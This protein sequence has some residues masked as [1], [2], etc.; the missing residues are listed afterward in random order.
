MKRPG[1]VIFDCDGVLVDSE[2]AAVQL[3]A[4]SFSRHGLPM[5]PAEIDLH[6][7]GGTMA[8]AGQKARDMGARLPAT[9]VE[10][11][12]EELYARLAAGTPL[13]DGIERVLDRLD[14]AGI[15]Y[16]VGSNGSQRKMGI[17]L[18]QH[19]ALMAR[20]AGRLYS[21]QD[22]LMTKPD[23]G[24][25]LRIAADAGVD[26]AACAVVDDSASGVRAGVAAGMRTL[27]F[28][29]HDEGLRLRSLGAEVFHRMADLPA[30]LGL[31]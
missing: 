6:F 25:F 12:Y 21:G 13:I 2:P 26:P 28:A 11:T 24:M 27:G 1:Y 10:D 14:A 29:A 22:L 31:G 20:L 16:A 9:W 3:L 4:E 8:G 7:V 17:T 23:P 19:P 18:G 30:L 15:G 5:T